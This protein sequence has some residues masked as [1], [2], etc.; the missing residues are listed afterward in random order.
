[1]IFWSLLTIASNCVAAFSL[2]LSCSDNI[3]T[4]CP[5]NVVSCECGG[6]GS[7][8]WRVTAESNSN[9]NENAY[10]MGYSA[11]STEQDVRN[12][13]TESTGFGFFSVVLSQLEISATSHNFSSQLNI[14]LRETVTV[15]CADEMQGTMVQLKVAGKL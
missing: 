10:R 7:L 4:L 11:S 14:T 13:A 9:P 5:E 2:T 15:N 8:S 1:M 6:V 3:G 12:V